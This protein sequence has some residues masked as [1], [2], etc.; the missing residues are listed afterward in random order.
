MEIINLKADDKVQLSSNLP[1]A[2]KISKKNQI[3]DLKSGVRDQN[4]VNI[5]IDDKF[6]FSLDLAQVVDYHL[7]IGKT[8]TPEEINDLRRASAFGKLYNQTLEWA[9][10]RP[11]SI[12]ETRDYLK[13]KLAKLEIDNRQRKDNREKAQTDPEF[14]KLVRIHKIRTAPREVF[15]IDDIERTIERLLDKGYLDDYKFAEWFIENRFINKGV[16]HTR[17]RQELH[18]K[19]ISS[20]IVDELLEKSARDEAA[21]IQKVIQKKSNKL[22][23]K[24]ML[25][26]LIRHGF[27]FDL[28]RELISKHYSESTQD[29][30]LII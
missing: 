2:T 13:Q 27:S 15:T 7:K 8:L 17:L 29:P 14:K 1:N 6:C 30:E 12:K 24:K 3:T 26:Y 5:F 19:G 11:R 4:R 18:K 9:L 21:E 16:S 20:D 22:D 10:I 25:A 23:S 28:S